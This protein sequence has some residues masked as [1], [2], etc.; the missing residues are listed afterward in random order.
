[1][2]TEPDDDIALVRA[3]LAG[4]AGAFGRLYDRYAPVVRAA[5]YDATGDLAQAQ[6]L[7]Q[8]AFL[9]AYDKLPLLSRPDRFGPWLVGIARHVCRE[10]RRGRARARRHA[11][12][13]GALAAAARQGGSDGGA[14]AGVPPDE[15]ARL[16]DAIARLP[17]GEREALHAFYLRGESADEAARALGLSRSGFYRALDRA[18]R[19][20]RR[21]LGADLAREGRP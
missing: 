6:D 11:A 15:L 12:R 5:C 7:G 20:L 3:T 10:W 18:T 21:A 8:D 1:M 16:R 9:R 17:A 2:T 19:R 4:D 14:A 13:A